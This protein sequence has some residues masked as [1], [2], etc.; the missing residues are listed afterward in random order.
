MHLGWRHRPEL[1]RRMR[2]EIGQ[3]P[4]EGGSLIDRCN[5]SG[6]VAAVVV[7]GDENG[8]LVEAEFL[9]VGGTTNIC[10]MVRRQESV[11][12]VSVHRDH[13][14]Q[15]TSTAVEG[16]NVPA[17]GRVIVHHVR[18][19][20]GRLP[21]E[22][23]QGLVEQHA[24]RGLVENTELTVNRLDDK[25]VADG[26]VGIGREETA[27]RAEEVNTIVA[28]ADLHRAGAEGAIDGGGES[29][30]GARRVVLERH[31]GR[32]L[33]LLCEQ[34]C[35]GEG[36]PPCQHYNRELAYGFHCCYS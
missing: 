2:D 21:K 12:R 22:R 32:R 36:K 26:C 9:V 14:E 8:V 15:P 29:S 27:A 34:R 5:R 20:A 31:R 30:L 25:V 16:R 28:L 19:A 18:V 35:G 24:S 17:V 4:R 1:E 13:Q 33:A 10:E 7:I 3:S 23:C 6:R 11:E